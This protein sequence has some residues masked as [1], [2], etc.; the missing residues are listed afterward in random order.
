MKG[1]ERKGKRVEKSDGIR[2]FILPTRRLL[3]C[4]WH[5]PGLI[6]SGWSGPLAASWSKGGQGIIQLP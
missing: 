6:I 3:R 2:W 1:K 4:S 5:N